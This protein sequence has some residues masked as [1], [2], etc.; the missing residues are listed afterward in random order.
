MTRPWET[1]DRV[2]TPDGPLELRRRGERDFLITIRGRVL[3]TSS[4]H[5]SEDELARLA[6]AAL[7]EPKRP[8]VLVSGLGMAFTLRAALDVLPRDARVIVAELNPVVVEWCR[9]PLGV[10]TDHA[11]A[12]PRVSVVIDDVSKVIAEHA[13]LPPERRFDAVVLDMY[14]GPPANRIPAGDPLYGTPA[15]G[16]TRAALRPGGVFAIWTENPSPAFERGLER[17]GFAVELHR[18]GRGGRIHWNYVARR[19]ERS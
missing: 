13:M 11:V 5:R 9:G 19:R 17:A 14:E 16:R 8:R 2:E 18:G 15:L 10:L 3:M 1:I 7:P 6:C 12:D 4:A